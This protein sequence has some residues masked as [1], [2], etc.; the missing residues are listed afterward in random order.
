[1]AEH[2][3]VQRQPHAEDDGDRG[4]PQPPPRREREPARRDVGPEREE[5]EAEDRDQQGGDGGV[6]NRIRGTGACSVRHGQTLSTSGWPSRPEGRKM[7]TM[8]RIEKA[9]TSLYSTV[10]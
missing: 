6:A 1:A 4:E 5:E 7:S 9:A 10:K 2:Q 8:A 3:E